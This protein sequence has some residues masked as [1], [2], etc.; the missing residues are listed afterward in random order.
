M[1]GL[2]MNFNKLPP[3]ITGFVS[4]ISQKQN[5]V[6]F[7][8]FKSDM[9]KLSQKL[10]MNFIACNAIITCENYFSCQLIYKGQTISILCNTVYPLI[11]ICEAENP[12]I[13]P[14]KFVSIEELENYI[15]G[16]RNYTVVTPEFLHSSVVSSAIE[17]LS[18]QELSNINYWQPKEINEIVFN[19]WD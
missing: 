17:D 14:R 4:D 3:G 11:G 18:V 10:H 2:L 13:M 1:I 12:N 15:S 8:E 5:A 7:S 6:S 9:I 19:F 16:L